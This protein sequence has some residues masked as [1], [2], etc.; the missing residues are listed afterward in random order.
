MLDVDLAAKAAG[1][2][3]ASA[4]RPQ[5]DVMDGRFAPKLTHGADLLAR[6]DQP[7]NLWRN[8]TVPGADLL[9][10]RAETTAHLHLLPSGI[11][12]LGRAAG[13]AL[14]PAT[15]LVTAAHVLDLVDL[16]L[17]M[18]VNPG[19][20]GQ[21]LI[22]AALDKVTEA[23][24]LLDRAGSAAD[25]EVDGGVSVA[26]APELV[27]RGASVLVAGSAV[28]RHPGGRA[29]VISELRQ[30]AKQ[31]L[32]GTDPGSVIPAIAGRQ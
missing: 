25:L 26:L 32:I 7:E 22:P 11:P 31:G 30:A 20:G 16:L 8:L 15:A 4:G 10:V 18:T 12:G 2:E 13:V 19:R 23:P 27:R 6:M 1:L 24:K 9:I 28:H 3:A 14:N 17:I 5:R 21:A 29:A